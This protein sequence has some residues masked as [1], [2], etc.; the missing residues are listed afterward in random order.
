MSDFDRVEAQRRSPYRHYAL[1]VLTVIFVVNFMDRQILAVLLEDL[2]AEF[3]LSDTQ[4]SLLSGLAFSM[5]YATMGIPIARLADRANRMN[6]VSIAIVVWSL[7]T[8]LSGA[9]VGFVSLFLA[10]MGVGIGEAG[11]NPPTQSILADY[12]DE[13]EL[14]RAMGLYGTGAAL[15]GVAGLAVGGMVSAAYGWRWAFVV[16]GLP[17]IVLGLLSYLTVREPA[18]APGR[19]ITDVGADSGSAIETA[20]ALA[21]NGAYRDAVLAL[22]IGGMSSMAAAM[23]MPA[24]F[25]RNF[26]L[27]RE[28][29]IGYVGVIYVAG[30]LFGIAAGGAICSRLMQ[31]DPRWIGW[32]PMVGVALGAPILALGYGLPSNPATSAA[33]LAL[34]LF[35]A[36]FHYAPN[37]S[38]VQLFVSSDRRAF[39]ASLLALSSNIFSAALGPLIVGL[40]SDALASDL[41]NLSLS[42]ANALFALLGLIAPFFSWRVARRVGERVQ[43]P[44]TPT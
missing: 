21:R 23:W 2:K 7:M 33:V 3:S 31:R 14:P 34:G 10:R 8:A 42:R 16:A 25:E 41:G 19:L 37:L 22:S 29:V 20:R 17:G 5:F 43:V 15:G 26:D 27:G 28:D 38:A 39:A 32:L 6:L 1:A 4:L 18:R 36:S 40:L 9:S 35:F 13:R 44:S 11:S 24:V 12:Y 30:S